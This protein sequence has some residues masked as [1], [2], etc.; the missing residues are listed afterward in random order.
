M[1]AQFLLGS[2][3]DALDPMLL[4][5]PD[6]VLYILF[7]HGPLCAHRQKKKKKKKK[8]SAAGKPVD[9]EE[10]AEGSGVSPA[11]QKLRSVSL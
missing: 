6:Y 8:A 2:V 3:A 11:C 9:N 1:L 5:L 10:D 4:V 7:C